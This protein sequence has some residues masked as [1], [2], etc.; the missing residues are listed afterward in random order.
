MMINHHMSMHVHRHM[1][2][3]S[4]HRMTYLKCTSSEVHFSFVNLFDYYS[5]YTHRIQHSQHI[6]H[7]HNTEYHDTQSQQTCIQK[8][9]SRDGELPLWVISWRLLMATP[10][11]L[12]IW[13]SCLD[14]GSSC[15]TYDDPC[16]QNQLIVP[17]PLYPYY[18]VQKLFSRWELRVHYVEYIYMR[19]IMEYSII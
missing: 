8:I 6:V 3:V 19:L 4:R 9:L 17:K 1:M 11:C 13:W 10:P 5:I 14:I 18:S 12:Y 15:Q 2:I 16:R 7:T